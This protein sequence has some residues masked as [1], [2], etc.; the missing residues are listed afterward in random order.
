MWTCL[1][2]QLTP[3]NAPCGFQ[4]SHNTCSV[5]STVPLTAFLEAG[6]ARYAEARQAQR[7]AHEK[8]IRTH[9]RKLNRSSCFAQFDDVPESV[10]LF[11]PAEIFCSAALEQDSSRIEMGVEQ[12]VMIVTPTTRIALRKSRSLGMDTGTVA[13]NAKATSEP[14]QELDRRLS[15]LRGHPADIARDREDAAKVCNSAIGSVEGRVPVTAGKS[16]D[17]HVT[18]S[19]M[20]LKP[21]SPVEMSTGPVV[22]Q[23]PSSGNSPMSVAVRQKYDEDGRRQEACSARQQDLGRGSDIELL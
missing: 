15:Q 12:N 16:D 4:C 17:P 18:V 23:S 6:D 21:V 20:N 22:R 9:F 2:I 1:P 3:G 10:V 11:L 14:G 13:V 7:Q 5:D 8:L 19:G